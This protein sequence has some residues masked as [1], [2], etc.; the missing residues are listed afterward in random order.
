M[1]VKIEKEIQKLK[2][3]SGL[4][5]TKDSFFEKGTFRPNQGPVLFGISESTLRSWIYQPDSKY[6]PFPYLVAGKVLLISRSL[7]EDWILQVGNITP[8][9]KVG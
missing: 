9:N 3:P 1:S 6:P 4:M 5:A 8:P 2:L 7:F